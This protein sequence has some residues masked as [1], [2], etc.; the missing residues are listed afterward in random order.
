VQQVFQVIVKLE[1]ET[2]DIAFGSGDTPERA[3][4][5]SVSTYLPC[6]LSFISYF[7]QFNRKT[8]LCSK[9]A[10]QIYIMFMTL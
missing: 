4:L 6:S 2:K 10:I 8:V 7:M 9:T 5:L 1:H 3:S